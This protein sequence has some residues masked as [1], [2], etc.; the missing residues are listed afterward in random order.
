LIRTA[1]ILGE[2]GDQ[3]RNSM[4]QIFYSSSFIPTNIERLWTISL[5][6]CSHYP[7]SISL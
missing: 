3:Q 7:P 6:G 4:R 1:K 2:N 5:W